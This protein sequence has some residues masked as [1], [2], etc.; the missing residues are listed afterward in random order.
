MRPA[1]HVAKYLEFD[2]G[3]TFY[4]SYFGTGYIGADK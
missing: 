3:W 4:V 2:A 1:P